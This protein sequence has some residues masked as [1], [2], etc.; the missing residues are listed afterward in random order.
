[1]TSA[2]KR[3]TRGHVVADLAVNHVERA[4]LL[5]GHTLNPIR[6]DYGVDA[7]VDFYGRDGRDLSLSVALQVRGSDRP[8]YVAGGAFVAARVETQHLTAWLNRSLIVFLAVYDSGRDRAYA[9]QVRTMAQAA[10]AG[11]PPGRTVT[12]RVPA[13]PLTPAGI[14]LW[15]E[16]ARAATEAATTGSRG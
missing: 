12:L 16:A 7:T 15:L 1:M 4:V 11:R 14:G 13:T 2:T 3:R 6:H 9:G 5:A 8:A 10:L